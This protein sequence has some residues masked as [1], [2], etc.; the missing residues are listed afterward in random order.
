MVA[1]ALLLGAA[2]SWFAAEGERERDEV[3]KWSWTP[4][5]RTYL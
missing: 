2:V 4:V 1:A 5:R 3:F